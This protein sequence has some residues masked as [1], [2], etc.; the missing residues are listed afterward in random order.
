MFFQ[1][2]G[3]ADRKEME[4][5]L[6]ESM[7]SKNELKTRA[8]EAVNQWRAK[9]RRLQKELEEARNQ[10][11]FHNNKALQVSENIQKLQSVLCLK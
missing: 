5:L 11:E 4:A 9:C 6:Q 1:S 3:Q 7:K 10:A 8:Q 2:R